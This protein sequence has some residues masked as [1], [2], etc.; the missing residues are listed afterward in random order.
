[1][2]V[3]MENFIRDLIFLTASRTLSIGRD[4]LA[5]STKKPT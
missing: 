5:F 2:K 1:M 3:T 4:G